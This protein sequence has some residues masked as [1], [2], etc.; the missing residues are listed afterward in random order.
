MGG[1]MKRRMLGAVAMIML[2]AVVIV[3]CVQAQ[4]RGRVDVPFA[5]HA[6]DKSFPAGTYVVRSIAEHSVI[7][8]NVDDNDSV[9]LIVRSVEKI[10]SQSSKLVFHAYGN[11]RFLQQVWYGSNIGIEIPA[12]GQEKELRMADNEKNLSYTVIAMR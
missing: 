4:Q 7:I 3:P 5:F 10:D 12:G 6:G 1:F 9:M 8:R 11:Q 2:A